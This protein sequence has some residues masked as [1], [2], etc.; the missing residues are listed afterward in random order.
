METVTPLGGSGLLSEWELVLLPQHTF[1]RSV[2]ELV[3]QQSSG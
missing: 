3:L 2:G 1:G